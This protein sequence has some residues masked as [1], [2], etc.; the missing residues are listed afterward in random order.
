[1]TDAEATKAIAKIQNYVWAYGNASAR[2][3]VEGWDTA[4]AIFCT[5][6]AERASFIARHARLAKAKVKPSAPALVL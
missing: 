5:T 4:L 1:M 6:D 2:R 3:S